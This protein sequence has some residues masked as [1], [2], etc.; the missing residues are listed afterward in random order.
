MYQANVASY[1]WRTFRVALGWRQDYKNS[2]FL[3][4]RL[5]ERKEYARLADATHCFDGYLDCRDLGASWSRSPAGKPKQPSRVGLRHELYR[6]QTCHP[7]FGDNRRGDNFCG[8]TVSRQG[9]KP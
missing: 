9:Q 4:A 6:R 2:R 3:A 8:L 7:D 1:C 5:V